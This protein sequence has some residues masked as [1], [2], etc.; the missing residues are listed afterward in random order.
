METDK[1]KE[2]KGKFMIEAVYEAIKNG[3]DVRQ[4]LSKFRQCMK[5]EAVPEQ[6]DTSV[7]I[8]LLSAEDPKER[9]NAALVLGDL[10][11]QEALKPLYEAYEKE[12]KKFVKSSYLSAIGK[13]DAGGLIEE[14]KH[15]YRELGECSPKEEDKK[16]VNTQLKELDRILAKY[17]ERKKHTFTGYDRENVVILTTGKD[18]YDVTAR[19]VV[20]GKTKP[21]PLGVLVATRD[22]KPLLSIRTYRE[23]LFVVPHKR[24]IGTD[25]KEAGEIL[26]DCGLLP[27]LL[28]CHDSGAPFFFRIEVRSTMSPDEKTAFVKKVAAVIEEKTDRQLINSATDYEVELRLI[29]TRSG[30]FFPCVKLQTIP[31]KRFAYRK[32]SI[33]ASIHPAQAALIM[34]LVK[35]YLKEDAQIMDPFCGVGTMLIER[36]KLVPA[37]EMYGI[38]LFGEAI[39]KA[40]ENTQNAG[41]RIWYINRDFFDFTHDYKFDEIITDMPPRGK[42]TKEEQD[43]FYA[44]FFA[45]AKEHLE[46]EA[47]LIL[48]S[49]EIGFIKKQLRLDGSYKLLQEYCMRKKDGYYVFVIGYKG[50]EL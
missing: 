24:E 21:H 45:K 26:A 16:H 18:F 43:A 19:Q 36:N 47:V 34:Q 48:Y 6:A 27:L 7:F 25:A 50:G 28:E 15:I 38:D 13:L 37:R 10:G 14:L 29:Q 33:A 1:T 22:L 35:P 17:G 49:N 8:G 23:L 39:A 2:R 32:M 12:E 30:R 3:E 9:K 4:N 42:K 20:C 41:D 5:E 46:R 40:R 31:M 44:R 11:A